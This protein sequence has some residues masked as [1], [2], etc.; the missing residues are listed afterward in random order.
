MI[1]AKHDLV[2]RIHYLF[3]EDKLEEIL[4]PNGF[5]VLESNS[6]SK[7]FFLKPLIGV[8]GI[9]SYS[10]ESTYIK[11]ILEAKACELLLGCLESGNSYLAKDS[12]WVLG[13]IFGQ[14]IQEIQNFL[15]KKEF[16]E[17]LIYMLLYC[18]DVK[19]KIELGNIFFNI[20]KTFF[21]QKVLD[22]VWLYSDTIFSVFL[23]VLTFEE[24][25]FINTM[26]GTIKQILY[27][28]NICIG[29]GEKSKYLEYF[30]S[31]QNRCNLENLQNHKNEDV[32]NN[33][34]ELIETYRI[35]F[36]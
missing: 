4:I 35:K 33:T 21:P 23:E 28:E 36:D 7:L 22:F 19:V 1:N 13:N 14:N 5:K 17:K 6:K 10:S 31:Q 25:V 27:H 3:K 34:I 20:T 32:R 11:R 30:M 16:M 18:T 26:I 9:V 15:L 29:Q 8:F 24:P 12:A 2:S